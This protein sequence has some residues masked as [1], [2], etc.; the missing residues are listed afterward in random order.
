MFSY[1]FESTKRRTEISNNH[2]LIV[3]Y[4]HFPLQVNLWKFPGG[5]SNLAEDICKLVTRSL[6][7]IDHNKFLGHLSETFSMKNTSLILRT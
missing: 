1:L 5:L 7:F 3:N 2:H 4:V 6:D